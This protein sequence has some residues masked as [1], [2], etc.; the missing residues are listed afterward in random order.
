MRPQRVAVLAITLLGCSPLGP[1][2]P[3]P[4]A[5]TN[6]ATAAFSR[7]TI[8]ADV[9]DMLATLERVH[10]DLHSRVSRDSTRRMRD[11]FVASLPESAPRA[12][13]W[14]EMARIVAAFGDGHTAL[15]P[16]P[17]ELDRFSIAGGLI[18]PAGVALGAAKSLTVTGY[19]GSDSALARG[20]E[21]LAISGTSV[22]SLLR[23]F[24]A[25]ISGETDTWRDYIALNQFGNYLWYNGI[26]APYRVEVRASNGQTRGVSVRGERRDSVFARARRS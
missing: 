5:P 19:F 25:E 3:P 9:D 20:D 2:P 16:P 8:V 21:I 13:V 18:F 1:P 15:G 6:A 14:P 26:R 10:P 7:A 24:R 11:A 12:G 17:E 4:P 22:D 23:L